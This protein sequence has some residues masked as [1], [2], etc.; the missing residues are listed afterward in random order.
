MKRLSNKTR[1]YIFIS[2]G[3]VLAVGA[4]LAAKPLYEQINCNNIVRMP[5]HMEHASID[6]SD[7]LD[8]GAL[9]EYSTSSQKANNGIEIDKSLLFKE[10]EEPTEPGDPEEHDPTED[11]SEPIPPEEPKEDPV[12]PEPE[13][14]PE[15]TNAVTKNSIASTILGIAALVCTLGLAALII[16]F[17]KKSYKKQKEAKN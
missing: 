6:Y 17:V 12:E 16:I 15:D 10:E 8:I 2:A 7:G 5:S 3:A 14:V 13:P 4:A 9:M 1:N 11:P